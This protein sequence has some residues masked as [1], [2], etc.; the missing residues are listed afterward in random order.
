MEFVLREYRLFVEHC[1]LPGEYDY[2]SHFKKVCEMPKI[3]CLSQCFFKSIEKRPISAPNPG[4]Y[5]TLFK[6]SSIV[7]D[8][9]DCPQ[10]GS[11]SS[12]LA[13]FEVFV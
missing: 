11:K 6:K 5:L 1:T 3:R 7:F 9:A 13:R 12:Q 10:I 2:S 4:S 8:N